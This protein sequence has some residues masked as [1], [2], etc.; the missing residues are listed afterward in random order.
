MQTPTFR[1]TKVVA[2]PDAPGD[3]GTCVALER[4]SP[5]N[6]NA[7]V[8]VPTQSDITQQPADIQSIYEVWRFGASSWE[9]ETPGSTLHRMVSLSSK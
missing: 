9:Q 8:F 6:P 5:L 7:P 2:P 4:P 3:I 1:P